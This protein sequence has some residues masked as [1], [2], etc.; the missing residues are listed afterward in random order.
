MDDRDLISL[1]KEKARRFFQ[2]KRAN[3]AESVFRAIHELVETD[4]PADV[5]SLLTPLGGGIGIRGENCGAMIAGVLALALVYGRKDPQ[6]GSLEQQRS[7]LW[8]TS[9]LYTQFPHRFVERFGSL[10][11]W[12]LTQPHIY[13][14][15]KCRDFCEDLIAETAGLVMEL[16]LEAKAKGLDFPFQ[17][18]LLSQCAAATSCSIEEL[19][20]RK[21]R[22]EP[23]PDAKT[24]PTG[25]AR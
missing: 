2:G 19:I 14:T 18:N 12:E 17:R 25:K 5:A 13:G 7:L 20:R 15:K 21:E 22:G 10:Q 1:S 9:A 11:C 8:K 24:P 4:L 23:F 3:C 6:K 16:L